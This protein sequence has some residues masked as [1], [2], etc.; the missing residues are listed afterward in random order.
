MTIICK[1]DEVLTICEEKK[2]LDVR[3]IQYGEI[4]FLGDF[5]GAASSGEVRRRERRALAMAYVAATIKWRRE[6]SVFDW[7]Q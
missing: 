5:A 4:G 2:L 1:V 3:E 7:P 6:I